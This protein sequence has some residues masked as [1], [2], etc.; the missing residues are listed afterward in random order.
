RVRQYELTNI[1]RPG[2]PDISA[3]PARVHRLLQWCLEKDRK[4]RLAAISDA[5]RLLNEEPVQVL[6]PQATAKRGWLWAAVAGVLLLL[7]GVAGYGW[8]SATR[9]VT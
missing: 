9:P 7:G 2:E 3:A 5:R 4:K 8:W 6:A 1:L